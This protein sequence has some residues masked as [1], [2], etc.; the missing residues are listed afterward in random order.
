MTDFTAKQMV[1]AISRS[2]KKNSEDFVKINKSP[3]TARSGISAAAMRRETS[4]KKSRLQKARHR[5]RRK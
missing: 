3:K 5:A 4:K 1:E 2:L